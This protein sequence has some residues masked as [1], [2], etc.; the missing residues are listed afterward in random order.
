MDSCNQRRLVARIES[1]RTTYGVH[2]V[3]TSADGRPRK[4]PL[5][6]YQVLREVLFM[7][8]QSAETTLFDQKCNPV[9]D[10]S[11]DERFLGQLQSADQLIRRMWAEPSFPCCRFT[12]SKQQVPLL[13]AFQ[14]ETS[15]SLTA[16][17]KRLTADRATVCGN[18]A[19]CGRESDQHFGGA[20]SFSGTGS[21]P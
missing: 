16:F 9:L 10:L 20:A 5:S 18:Q 6:E 1:I 14:D 13:Q 21:M 11:V 3:T 4:T 7:L 8:S 19:G 2:T 17:D 12:A 15:Q